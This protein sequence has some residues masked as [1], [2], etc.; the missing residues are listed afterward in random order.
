M[1]QPA[2]EALDSDHR[3]LDERHPA[4]QAK[5]PNA[6]VEGNSLVVDPVRQAFDPQL[7]RAHADLVLSKL[8]EHLS[9]STIRGLRLHDPSDLSEAA[10]ALMDPGCDRADGLIASRLAAIVDLYVKTGIQVHSPGS[11]GRQFSG[12]VPLAGVIDFVS[13]VVSQPSSF[14]EAGQLPNVVER[15]MSEELGKLIGWTPGT[16]AMVT[17]SGGSLANLTALLAAR[18]R[19]YPQFWDQGS[20]GRAHSG[21]RP[22]IAVGADA[23][24]SVVRAAGIMGIGESQVLRLAL[25]EAGRIRVESVRPVLAEARRRGLDVFCLVATMGST[26]RGAF[27]PI[28][29]L[30]RIARQHRIWLHVDGAHGASLLVSEQLRP[31]TGEVWEADSLVWDAHKMLFVPAPCTLLFYRREEDSRSAFRQKASY[32]FAEQP[33]I[34]SMLDNG[35]RNFECT[36][37]P[38]IMG[39]WVVWALYG[40]TFFAQKIEAVCRVTEAAYELLRGEPDFEVL[41]RPES[42]IL[43]FRHRPAQLPDADVHDLQREIRDRVRLRGKFFIS[44]VD[45]DGV[46]ALR[47]VLTNHDTTIEHFRMLLDEIRECAALVPA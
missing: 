3:G 6:F 10:R 9:D 37:R 17:T 16:F 41:H 12:V 36:K 5:Q 4:R 13:S 33:D 8:Q 23:H 32:V 24:Y 31:R 27:D 15:I 40:R 14:Y 30:A 19:R 35:D 22:A 2:W 7:F 47:V 18:N 20:P 26:S 21:L 29:E 28:G 42:N 25:D 43:C 44:K 34:H 45:I 39:L 11:V 46:C 38:M 1:P